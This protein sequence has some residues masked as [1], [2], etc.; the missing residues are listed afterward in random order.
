M[1]YQ[2]IVEDTFKY[3]VVENTNVVELEI[4]DET[5]GKA[6]LIGYEP[7]IPVF[8]ED[9]YSPPKYL[10]V[11]GVIYDYARDWLKAIGED[12]NWEPYEDY[13]YDYGWSMEPVYVFPFGLMKP[14]SKATLKEHKMTKLSI[15]VTRKNK[16]DVPNLSNQEERKRK[17]LR[18]QRQEE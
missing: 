18:F 17:K 6:Q 5:E 13:D 4:T 3:I 14:I 9:G 8:D 1:T 16:N 12:N 10:I 7:Y 15:N 11:D 2:G